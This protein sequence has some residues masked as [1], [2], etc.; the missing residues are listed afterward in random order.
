MKDRLKKKGWEKA[1]WFHTI[2]LA[3]TRKL[4]ISYSQDKKTTPKWFKTED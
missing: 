3:Q 1:D 4:V 2:I